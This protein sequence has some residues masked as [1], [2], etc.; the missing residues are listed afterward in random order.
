KFC[1]PRNSCNRVN[2]ALQTLRQQKRDFGSSSLA[3][4]SFW[5]SRSE[6]VSPA[7]RLDVRVEGGGHDRAVEL[8][9]RVQQVLDIQLVRLH[10]EVLDRLV[11]APLVQQ[12]E[13]HPC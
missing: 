1:A 11:A 9:E 13:V 7:K 4:R 8:V 6:Q 10:E 2:A 5:R 3:A 12:Q